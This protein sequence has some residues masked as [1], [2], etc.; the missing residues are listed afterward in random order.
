MNKNKKSKREKILEMYTNENLCSKDLLK[1]IK[2]EKPSSI[3]A[4]L[5]SEKRKL[6]STNTK[7]EA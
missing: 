5:I 4:V 7:K 2:E 6:N 1:I 3:Y